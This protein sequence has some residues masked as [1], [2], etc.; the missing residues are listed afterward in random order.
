LKYSSTDVVFVCVITTT[1]NK[2]N[3]NADL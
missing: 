2:N 3:D 1:I